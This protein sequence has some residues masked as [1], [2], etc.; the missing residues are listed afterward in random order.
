MT[1]QMEVFIFRIIWA[2]FLGCCLAFGF[3]RSWKTERG[4]RKSWRAEESTAVWIDPL[5]LPIILG[6]IAVVYYGTRGFWEGGRYLLSIGIEVIIF[7]SIYFTFLLFFLPFL[8]KYY[9]A[10]TCAT[11]WLIPVF[12]FY[13]PQI[14]YN[15]AMPPR[16]V[17]YIPGMILKML[18][19]VWGIG[20][21]MIFTAQIISHMR[22]VRKLKN[23]SYPVEDS[24]LTGKWEYLKK[25]MNLDGPIGLRYCRIIHTPLTVGM[26]RKS[27]I[28]YL[29]EQMYAMEDAEMIFSHELHHIRRNDTHTK[30]FLKFC[31]AL[32]WF[33]PF[34]WIA[35]KKAEED[36]ELSCDEIVLKDAGPERRKRYAELLLTTAGNNRGFTTCLSASANT[37]RYRMR[38]IVHGREKRLGTLL[39]FVVMIA[40]VLCTGK[41]CFSTD[42]RTI[43]EILQFQEKGISEAGIAHKESLEQYTMIKD[44]QELTEYLAERHAERVVSPYAETLAS[45]G[46]NL[47][48]IV[49]NTSY[50]YIF[51]NY[52]EM[53]S[54]GKEP[55][56]YH[57]TEP[58]DWEYITHLSSEENSLLTE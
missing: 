47:Y 43:G 46:T 9:T 28:T 38:A 58:I 55:E 54:S 24:E 30:F 19:C 36:L 41:I 26:R 13:Q 7:I 34:V 45:D 15:I 35:V 1:E 31:N 18:V 33:H 51:D 10:R 52:M 53:R 25:E 32:G 37:L 50:F 6:F 44:T 49:E 17:F 16:T 3:R 48:G 27:R 23:E 20:F 12:L 57:L 56:L 11:F 40:S 8:R 22:F 39:L 21:I 42:Q 4:E 2:L 14:L 5:A 29:P